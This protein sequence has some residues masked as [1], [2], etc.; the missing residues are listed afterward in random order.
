MPDRVCWGT[1]CIL[2]CCI[3]DSI[4][5]SSAESAAVLS[6]TCAIQGLT[7][8]NK[9]NKIRPY[10]RRLDFFSKRL[11]LNLKDGDGPGRFYANAGKTRYPSAGGPRREEKNCSAE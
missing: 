8:K 7:E 2:F 1:G 9:S 10:K 6:G 3:C 11:K 5:F 4:C